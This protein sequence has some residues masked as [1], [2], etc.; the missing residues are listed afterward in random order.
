MSERDYLRGDAG[1]SFRGAF[2]VNSPATKVLLLGICGIHFL[3]AVL[4]VASPEGYAALN[5]LLRL[6]PR[7]VLEGWKLWQI[8]TATFLHHDLFHLLFNALNL[9]FFGR[10]V[11]ERLGTRKFLL[12]CLGAAVSASFGYLLWSLAQRSV[13]PMVGASG[14]VM[15]LLIAAALWYPQLTVVFF[16][17]P[18]PLWVLA[19]IL[20]GMDLLM[21]FGGSPD[22]AHTAHLAGALFGWIWVRHAGL[23]DPLTR[24]FRRATESRRRR[25]DL[26][27]AAEEQHLRGRVDAILDKVN[28]EGMSALTEEERRFL[29]EASGRLRR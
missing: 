25:Q 20:V 8:V 26:R 19:A 17:F 4:R 28:R 15:G 11:E 10:M 22:I 2:W 6:S 24:V 27:R 23:F 3:L 13:I 9:Y 12:F 7:D 1:G 21:A 5:R 14:A 29:K 18:M 16:V